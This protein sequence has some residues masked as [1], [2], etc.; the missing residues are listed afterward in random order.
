MTSTLLLMLLLLLMLELLMDR[1]RLGKDGG[2]LPVFSDGRLRD[3]A[4]GS[5]DNDVKKDGE[6]S[7]TS[8]LWVS[9]V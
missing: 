4:N 3:V 9:I 1:L 8:P 2:K 7:L 5:E 6:S